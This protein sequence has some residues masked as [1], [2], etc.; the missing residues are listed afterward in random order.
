M[1]RNKSVN[2]HQF[3]MVPKAEIPR[4]SFRQEHA[5]KTTINASTLVPVY[6]DEMLPGDTFNL[7]MTAFGRLATP[8]FPTLDNLHLESFFFFVPNRLVWDNWQPFMGE[9]RTPDASIDYTIPQLVSP[10]NGFVAGDLG[11]F[12]GLPTVGQV[13]PGGT[14]S[15]N[16]LPFRAYNLIYNEWFRD[17]NL[18]SP[19]VVDTDDGPDDPNDYTIV[20]RGKR[21]DYFTGCLPWPQKGD[22]VPL[23]LGTTAPIYGKGAQGYP[24]VISVMDGQPG[25]TTAR[26]LQITNGSAAVNL[27]SNATSS[28]SLTFSNIEQP[29]YVDLSSATAA[30]INQLRQSFQ[31]QKL[32]ERDA[33]GGSRYTEI[34]RAHFGVVSP[35]AR[36]QRPEYLGGGH[37]MVNIAPVPQTSATAVEG[38]DTPQGTLAATGTV[39]A[40]GHGFTYSATEHGYVI[41][42]VNVRADITYQQGIRRM[43]SRQTRYDFYFPVFATLGEQ[44]VLRKEIYATGNETD[45]NVF[46]YQERWADMR[47]FPSMVTGP[48][49][50]SYA[51][52]LDTWHLVQ[53][54]AV[55]PG[56]GSAFIAEDP[57]IDRIIAVPSEP[58]LLLDVW[59]N[60]KAARPMPLYSVP[61]LTR[62]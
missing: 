43:W 3:S 20:R 6:V 34:I 44:A 57:P 58:H 59:T 37:S 4:S 26:N 47:Y 28:G 13:A 10:V 32:L 31:I 50:S 51:Q 19:L 17:Q 48:M 23:P 36:L 49:R 1:H 16:A 35:D 15:V 60:I 55:R 9:R 39:L 56:L 62:M 30:T 52:S 25:G 46:G 54:F 45:D 2:V 33:R 41:G 40:N 38:S 18:Q 22:S 29:L 61:G 8:L 14:V 21:H 5:Y 11:D 27:S 7:R 24:Q 12:F 53:D 42:L